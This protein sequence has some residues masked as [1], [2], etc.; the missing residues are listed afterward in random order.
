MADEGTVGTDARRPGPAF[1]S[2]ENGEVVPG[3]PPP[4]RRPGGKLSRRPPGSGSSKVR[5]CVKSAALANPRWQGQVDLAV[6]S[7]A[8]EDQAATCRAAAKTHQVAMAESG[9]ARN[10]CV[11]AG[12]KPSSTT[13]AIAAS[14]SSGS[15]FFLSIEFSGSC[16]VTTHNGVTPRHAQRG[17]IWRRDAKTAL[18]T[19]PRPHRAGSASDPRSRVAH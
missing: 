9:K 17:K 2:T 14:N 1:T 8:L 10:E 12:Q 13:S 11:E 5:R 7:A 3:R 16:F 15:A 4:R 6:G 19:F 18:G